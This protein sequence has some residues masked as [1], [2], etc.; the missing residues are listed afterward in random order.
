MGNSKEI[1]SLALGLQSPWKVSA[2]KL[3]DI[4][5]GKELHIYITFDKFH[6]IKEINEAMDE[7]RKQ[8]RR[9]NE[10]LKGHK[11]TFLKNKLKPELQT[12]RDLLLE[13]YPKLG[14]GYRLVELFKD[15]WEIKDKEEA[16][17]YQAFWC[18]LAIETGIA[19][20]HK[21]VKTIKA[22]W[23]GIINYYKVKYVLSYW[24]C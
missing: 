1:F 5:K 15:F 4:E 9:G 14:E 11:Y 7:L 21:A 20:F 24:L 10:K 12:E 3:E 18:D 6:V 22:H 19:S 23:R 8:E 13:M 17:G 16:E 2:V